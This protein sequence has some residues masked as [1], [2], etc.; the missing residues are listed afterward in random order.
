MHALVGRVVDR[1]F[2]DRG[3][4]GALW[5]KIDRYGSIEQR[6]DLG[7]VLAS[8]DK[9]QL[10]LCA[11]LF[12]HTP[13]EVAISGAASRATIF[14]RLRNLRLELLAAGLAPA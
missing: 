13:T 6:L 2:S 11:D 4:Y 12:Q 1:T 7:K 9:D 14:R 10:S 5:Q 8:L 3:R